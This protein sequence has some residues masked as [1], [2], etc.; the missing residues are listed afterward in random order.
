MTTHLHQVIAAE[1]GRK[2]KYA[3]AITE[4][5]T[6]FGDTGK[7]TGIARSYKPYHEDGQTY[8]SESTR[9]QVKAGEL[10][11]SVNIRLAELIDV[12]ATKDATNCIATADVVID[13]H[14]L[15]TGIPATTLLFLEKQ[16][17]E[18]LAFVRRIP[19]LDP[20]RPWQ[21]DDAQDCWVSQPEE[22]I[23]TK[24]SKRSMQLFEG[25][26]FHQPQIHV[27]DEDMPEGTWT[28]YRYSGAMRATDVNLIISRLER[29]QAAVTH[30]REAANRAEAKEQHI[31]ESLLR[32][33]FG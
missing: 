7:L 2:E 20:A 9:V 22:T 30:A 6:L 3:R 19:V 29:L 5:L 23:R 33:V 28:T 12:I 16:L 31:G 26:Q 17:A 18:L 10:T 32:Y 14:T 13:G 1:K 21:H 8:P 25:N 11:H 24:K 27:W 4:A 15:L